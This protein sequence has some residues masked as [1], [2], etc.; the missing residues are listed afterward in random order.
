M[1]ELA[2]LYA[3]L[4]FGTLGLLVFGIVGGGHG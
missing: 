3:F 4:V 2:M 1:S